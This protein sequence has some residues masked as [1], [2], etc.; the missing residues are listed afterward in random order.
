MI[1]SENLVIVSPVGSPGTK[2]LHLNNKLLTTETAQPQFVFR[3]NLFVTTIEAKPFFEV[4]QKNGS[5]KSVHGAHYELI[6]SLK[7][8]RC[9]IIV[10]FSSV[11]TEDSQ[12]FQF[13]LPLLEFFPE[14][15]TIY[16]ERYLI[17]QMKQF[18]H[19]VRRITHNLVFKTLCAVKPTRRQRI[20]P[21]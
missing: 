4:M 3:K 2:T 17:Q 6:N 14:C 18:R 12:K 1:S 19:F 15:S 9:Q 20:C 8:Q 5:P 21:L 10:S 11:A 7:K 13:L 16:S